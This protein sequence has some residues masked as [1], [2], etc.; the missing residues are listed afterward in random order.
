MKIEGF[1]KLWM[2][3]CLTMMLT[4]LGFVGW[5]ILKVLGYFGVI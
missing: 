3:F 4:V 5:V 2:L 1:F